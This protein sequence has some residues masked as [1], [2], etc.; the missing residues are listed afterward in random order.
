MDKI[1]AFLQLFH[2]FWHEKDINLVILHQKREMWINYLSCYKSESKYP[3]RVLIIHLERWIT[4]YTRKATESFAL[5][6][7]IS[8]YIFLFLKKKK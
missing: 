5:I 6:N 4:E 1:Q 2:R 7:L 3:Q 8:S